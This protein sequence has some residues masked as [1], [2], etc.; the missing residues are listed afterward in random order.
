MN[1]KQTLHNDVSTLILSSK[2][3]SWDANEVKSSGKSLVT[4]IRDTLWTIN[5]HIL[6]LKGTQFQL[7][8]LCLLGTIAPSCLST[9]KRQY[10][11]SVLKS[12]SS[13]LPPRPYW[14][15]PD[16]LLLNQM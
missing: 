7:L 2:G 11:C 14:D 16:W 10:V 1:N 9:P 5:G 3:C 6:E 15:R 13:P 12:L 8:S 4:A